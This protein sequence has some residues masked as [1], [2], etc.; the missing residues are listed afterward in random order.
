MNNL[1]KL[2]NLLSVSEK[3]Q[4]AYVAV[5]VLIMAIVDA[6]G[7]ASIMP[8]MTIATNPELASK[9]TYF[10]Q[11]KHLFGF[12]TNE[13]LI[14]AIGGGVLFVLIIGLAIKIY[15]I[16]IQQTFI[17]NCERG[18][19]TRLVN[20]YLARPYEWFVSI[21]SSGLGV[22]VLTEVGNVIS[23]GLNPV[24]TVFAQFAVVVFIGA[25]LFLI[26]P[27]ATLVAVLVFFMTYGT[28]M[29]VTSNF[30]KR[31][32]QTRLEENKNRYEIVKSIFSSFKEIKS[33]GCE[34]Y[35]GKK[36]DRSSVMYSSALTK[37]AMLAKLPRFFFEGMT[38]GSV[39]IVVLIAVNEKDGISEALPII[40]M[41]AIAG[42][43][44]MPAF[45]NIYSSIF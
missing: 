41:F 13:E 8:F 43:K 2:V 33:Y 40:S 27:A 1:K 26:S 34:S 17:Q 7:V 37:Q 44:L 29:I 19:S 14:I 12:A 16:Y 11:I 39:I 9:N 5:M 10:L 35:L 36:Y 45:Q 6:V 23:N 22:R 31:I 30:L 28:L 21:E 18:I 15:V 20:V 24:I 4:G 25:T 42:Y 3:K 38:F 32:S